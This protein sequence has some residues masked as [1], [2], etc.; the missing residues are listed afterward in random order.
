M[1][2]HYYYYYKMSK[3]KSKNRRGRGEKNLSYLADHDLFI[4]IFTRT[5]L[6][7][8]IYSIHI[9]SYLFLSSTMAILLVEFLFTY[10]HNRKQ[11]L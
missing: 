6:I 4:I 2:Y 11:D 3:V 10:L 9:I 7:I 5:F 1:L 8:I